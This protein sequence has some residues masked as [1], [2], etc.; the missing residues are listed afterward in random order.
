M[1]ELRK[2]PTR[3]RWVLMRSPGRARQSADE[4]PFCPGNEALTPPE[5]AA[6]RKDGSAPNT[7]GW[8]VRVIPEANPFFRVEWELIREGAGVYDKITPRGAS[9]LIIESPSHEDSLASMGEEQVERVLR[10]YR[11][12]IEDL[13]RD[14]QI[15]DILVTR[16]YKKPGSRIAHPYSRVI[17]IPIIF[18]EVRRE[19]QESR[20]YYRYKRRCVFC[21]I[22]RQEVGAEARVVRLTPF[23]LVLV[24]YVA[25]APLETWILPRQHHCAFE[26]ISAEATGDLAQILSG[27]FQALSRGFGD[28]SF[29]MALHTVP[30]LASKLLQEEWATVSEDYH[31][32][33][34]VSVQ[35]ERLNRVGGIFVNDLPPEDAAEQLRQAWR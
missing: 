29:E 22:L 2:D 19:L 24:P 32:H 14:S 12:R 23:F 1:S 18:D 16:R 27:Y 13:K 26:A 5:I 34:E 8:Q 20:E 31:W 7:L 33:L 15:R 11:D 17:A 6:Y 3:G 35:P 25:R 10:M 30:N 9:E 28:P 4:C 21:D